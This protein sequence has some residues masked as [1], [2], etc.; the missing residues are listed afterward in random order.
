MTRTHRYKILACLALA[1]LL[2]VG[3]LGLAFSARSTSADSLIQNLGLESDTACGTRTTKVSLKGNQGYVVFTLDN[4]THKIHKALPCLGEL[5]K[6][7]EKTLYILSE[8]SKFSVKFSRSSD[9]KRKNLSDV[10]ERDDS[11]DHKAFNRVVIV[12]KHDIAFT[13]MV[14]MDFG[15][16]LL[17]VYQG[18][19]EKGSTS[20]HLEEFRYLGLASV[21]VVADGVKDGGLRSRSS[22]DKRSDSMCSW[23][24]GVT[25]EKHSKESEG[26]TLNKHLQAV[27]DFYTLAKLLEEV[28]NFT[29]SNRHRS[30]IN[31]YMKASIEGT[32]Q[33]VYSKGNTKKGKAP[34]LFDYI[35]YDKKGDAIQN[36]WLLYG[37]NP[38]KQ[39]SYFLKSNYKNCSYHMLDITLVGKIL[40][41]LEGEID[42]RGFTNKRKALGK[43]SILKFMVDAYD[44]K[45]RDGLRGNTPTEKGGTF[46]TCYAPNKGYAVPKGNSLDY[47]RSIY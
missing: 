10:L 23:Y 28:D 46:G 32:N 35:P 31:D 44:I 17:R 39:K 3:S 5:R 19:L 4:G 11:L 15:K 42:L 40:E 2:L 26:G 33:L 45:I 8:E 9:G 47:L 38:E 36:S 21:E 34:N 22:C 16:W 18:L 41:N 14:Q 37:L 7:A 12:N 43:K 13:S 1:T 30:T 6:A 29:G 24:H 25:N 20:P 27:D